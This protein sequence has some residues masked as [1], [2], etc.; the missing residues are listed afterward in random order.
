[1]CTRRVP[2]PTLLT[3]LWGLPAECSGPCVVTNQRLVSN[4]SNV[5]TF[6]IMETVL[7]GQSPA[8]PLQASVLSPPCVLP[9]LHRLEM[10]R[11]YRLCSILRCGS[12]SHR[13]RTHQIDRAETRDPA[14]GFRG[15]HGAWTTTKA[16]AVLFEI[17][18]RV[19]GRQNGL[20]KGWVLRI[21]DDLMPIGIRQGGWAIAALDRVNGSGLRKRE[22]VKYIRPGNRTIH[23]AAARHRRAERHANGTTAAGKPYNRRA[24]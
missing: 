23:A 16:S 11:S 21:S 20:E 17:V 13:V 12:L 15:T 14:R 6:D 22:R 18:A 1:M 3:L 4:C 5:L 7:Y 2:S 9:P 24:W 8:G 10:S 19:D